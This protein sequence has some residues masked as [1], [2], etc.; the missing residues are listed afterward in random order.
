M[1]ERGANIESAVGLL[2]CPGSV[3]RGCE[4]LYTSKQVFPIPY[5]SSYHNVLLH[6]TGEYNVAG[7]LA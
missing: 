4:K 7:R 6:I 2:S 5:C 3:V 1:S